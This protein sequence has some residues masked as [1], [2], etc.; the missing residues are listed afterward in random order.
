MGG[1][2]LTAWWPVRA[3]LLAAAVL[4][5]VLLVWRGRRWLT[6]ALLVLSLVV[7]LP[8]NVLAGVNAYY[9]YYQTL[10]QALGWPDRDAATAATLDQQEAPR[11]GVLVSLAIPGH[12]SRFAARAA[13]VYLPPAWFARQHP[14]LPVLMLLHGTPGSPL[15]W[16]DG[17]AAAAILDQWAQAHH[18]LAP[19][20]VMPDVNGSVT[21]DTECVDSP[22]GNAETYLT[23]DVPDFVHRRFVTQ[24]PGAHWAVAG[25]SEGGSC[26]I[27]LALRHPSLFSTFGDY[28]GLAGPRVGNVNNPIRTI[29]TLF[30]GSQTAFQ[31]HEPAWLLTQHRY[32]GLAGW[33]EVGGEDPQAEDAARRLDTLAQSAGIATRLVVMPDNG[34]TFSVWRTALSDSLPWI[35]DH[36]GA[37]SLPAG[38]VLPH[39]PYPQ[40]KPSQLPRPARRQMDPPWSAESTTVHSRRKPH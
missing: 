3:T 30:A 40:V 38:A 11:H 14:R 27:M 36:L 28:S 19:I 24:P 10:G 32:P 13:E 6:R 5:V 29:N 12:V 8:V 16:V 7:V 18:G 34:H 37:G 23:T 39:P 35:V 4:I 1:L 25:L 15:D 9:G 20:V 31:Q 17:G 21:G 22:L 2:P 33:L 26:A